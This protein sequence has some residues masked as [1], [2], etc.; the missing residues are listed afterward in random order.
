MAGNIALNRRIVMLV[1]LPAVTLTVLLSIAAYYWAL[2]HPE[3]LSHSDVYTLAE[4]QAWQKNDARMFALGVLQVTLWFA[5]LLGYTIWFGQK[6][7]LL[8]HLKRS[9]LS[10]LYGLAQLVSL[11]LCLIAY[12]ILLNGLIHSRDLLIFGDYLWWVFP[13]IICVG[14]LPLILKKLN[15]QSSDAQ[16]SEVITGS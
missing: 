15:D 8:A 11:A 16:Q 12:S 7:I 10:K 9:W 4:N 13:A 14:G 6:V 5:P 3:W 1:W 2:A